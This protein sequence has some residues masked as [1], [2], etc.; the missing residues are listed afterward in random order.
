MVFNE[1][2]LRRLVRE[3]LGYYHADRIHDGFGK[4]TPEMRPVERREAGHG[5]L[6]DLA[7]VGGLQH[8]HTWRLAA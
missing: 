7:R 1:V 4:D 2:H 5:T 6:A 3:Y 8:R